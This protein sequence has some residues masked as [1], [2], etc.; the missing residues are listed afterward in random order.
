MSGGRY[1]GHSVVQRLE[2]WK[3]A[4]GIISSNPIIGVGTGDIQDAFDE[5]YEIMHSH[6]SDRWRLRAHNQYLTMFAVFGV[7]GFLLFLFSLIYPY[8]KEK[9]TMNFCYSVF[10]L[11]ILISM[12]T[13]DTL[14]TQ[15]GVTFYAF[16]NSLFLFAENKESM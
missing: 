15:A 13:E 11:I 1:D 5:Q 9:K 3:A 8:M 2:Y 12:I 10:L 14:E 16:F 7:V 4:L 6:L